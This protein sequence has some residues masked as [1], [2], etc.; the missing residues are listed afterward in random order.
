MIQ[1]V[2]IPKDK[3]PYLVTGIEKLNKLII[4]KF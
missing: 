2:T 3:K 1:E 4:I